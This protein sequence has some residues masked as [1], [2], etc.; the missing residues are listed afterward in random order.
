MRLPYMSATIRRLGIPMLFLASALGLVYALPSSI[1]PLKAEKRVNQKAELADKPVE[2]LR[3]VRILPAEVNRT[4]QAILAAAMSGDIDS[5]RV[6]IEMNE[7]PPIVA[8]EKV[9]DPI[10]YWKT[11]SGDGE[12]REILAILVKLLRTGFVEKHAGT[13]DALYVWPY[14]AEIP[15]D[16]LTPAQEVELLTLVSP[17]QFKAMKASG[18]Y[19][20][21][22]IG[23]AHDGTWHYFID[24]AD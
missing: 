20:H 23:I 12:G 2:I 22:R 15:T 24:Q 18:R 21:Y 17:S 3:D 14:F 6:P 19:D 5:M 11:L 16:A 10:A 7:I 9:A 4:R 13:G 8:R 1:S